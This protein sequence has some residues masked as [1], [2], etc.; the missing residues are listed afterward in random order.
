MNQATIDELTLTGAIR[1]ASGNVIFLPTYG[2]VY[3]DTVTGI[4]YVLTFDDGVQN[5]LEVSV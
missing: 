5:K 1:D 4:K 2:P 3:T